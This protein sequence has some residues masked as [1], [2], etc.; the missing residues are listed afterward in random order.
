MKRHMFVALGLGCSHS[1]R[2]SFSDAILTNFDEINDRSDAG[3]GDVPGFTVK[4]A[5]CST[6]LK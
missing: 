6:D 5:S 3:G 2:G 4:A 1:L